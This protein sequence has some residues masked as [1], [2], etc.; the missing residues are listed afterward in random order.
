MRGVDSHA[1]ERIVETLISS[2][3]NPTKMYPPMYIQ[4]KIYTHEGRLLIY[5][6]VQK[7]S[8]VTR[9]GATYFDRNNDSDIDVTNHQHV[10]FQLF[11]RKQQDLYGQRVVPHIGIDDLDSH[12]I[13]RVKEM[14]SKLKDNHMWESL[15]HRELLHST[16]L[17][18][19]NQITGKEGITFAAVLLFGS[20]DLIAHIF[21]Y[22]KTDA[23][24]RIVD[25]N[26]YDDRDIVATNLIDS[27]ERLVT[28]GQKH[29]NDIYTVKG[30]QRLSSHDIILREII[31]NSLSHHDYSSNHAATFMIKKDQFYIENGNIAHEFGHI[32]ILNIQPKAKIRQSPKYLENL[33]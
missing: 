14:A 15:D 7:S 32:D 18:A 16:G 12:L 9:C 24:V 22:Y 3:R 20:D 8:H 21:P 2:A 26:R 27:F 28:F 6:Y 4:P 33:G 19:H 1:V 10:M 29:L 23:L 17:S 5:V 25:T 30:L 31:S 11:S 13:Q